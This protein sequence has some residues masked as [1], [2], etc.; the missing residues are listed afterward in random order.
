MPIVKNVIY[1]NEVDKNNYS[2]FSC[3]MDCGEEKIFHYSVGNPIPREYVLQG[4]T[5]EWVLGFM[6]GMWREAIGEHQKIEYIKT[7]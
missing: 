5:W 6:S 2:K 1:S 4:N 3:V 7:S